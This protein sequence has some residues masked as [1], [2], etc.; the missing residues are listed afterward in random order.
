MCLVSARL[1]GDHLVGL[2]EN[3]GSQGLSSRSVVDLL[4]A[5]RPARHDIEVVA[6]DN[7]GKRPPNYLLN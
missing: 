2:G 5:G 6:E 3:E 7:V 4:K 1:R